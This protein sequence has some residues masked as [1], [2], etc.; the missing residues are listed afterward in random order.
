MSL[1]LVFLSTATPLCL[2]SKSSRRKKT[3]PAL[4]HTLQLQRMYDIEITTT[5]SFFF[6]SYYI[7]GE[8]CAKNIILFPRCLSR[9][10]LSDQRLYCRSDPNYPLPLSSKTMFCADI[11]NNISITSTVDL[12]RRTSST[13]STAYLAPASISVHTPNAFGQA[14]FDPH[15]T[16]DRF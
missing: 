10:P 9:S 7:E 4:L 1:T 8:A 11:G 3:F 14:S 16:L 5:L 2:D 13:T 12:P 6:R 15:G